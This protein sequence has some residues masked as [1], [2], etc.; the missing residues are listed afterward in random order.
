MTSSAML[1]ETTPGFAYQAKGACN[2]TSCET[3]APCQV[4]F[5]ANASNDTVFSMDLANWSMNRQIQGGVGYDGSKIK[6]RCG[7]TDTCDVRTDL[8]EMIPEDAGILANPLVAVF[9]WWW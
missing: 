1:I 2:G 9:F 3:L 4:F 7:I 6:D 8:V 5:I